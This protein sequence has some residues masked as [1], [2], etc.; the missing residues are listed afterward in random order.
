LLFQGGVRSAPSRRYN[1]FTEYLWRHSVWL[2]TFP[3]ISAAVAA[4][5]RRHP[6]A[7]L[8]G[9]YATAPLVA[10]GASIRL[11]GDEPDTTWQGYSSYAS[12]LLLHRE[13]ERRLSGA[14]YPLILLRTKPR[15]GEWI[16][17]ITRSLFEVE[18]RETASF[19]SGAGVRHVLLEPRGTVGLHNAQRGLPLARPETETAAR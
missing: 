4:S 11:L 2:D 1:V 3:A 16:S 17:P 7:V 15:G 19:V 14:S 12:P 18:Y 6:E 9:D 13:I 10:L 8:F 5:A